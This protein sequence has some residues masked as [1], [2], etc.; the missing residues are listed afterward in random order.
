MINKTSCLK[1]W[2]IS[3]LIRSNQLHSKVNAMNINDSLKGILSNDLNKIDSST[4][5]ANAKTNTPAASND[6][7]ITG[8]TSATKSS[9]LQALQSAVADSSSFN[10]GKVEDIKNAI[11]SGSFMIDAGKVADGMIADSIAMLKKA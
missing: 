10:A 6:A 5:I 11:A 3:P 8:N 7:V 1:I 2:C 9:Q 4:P